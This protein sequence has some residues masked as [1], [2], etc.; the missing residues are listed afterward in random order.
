MKPELCMR[1]TKNVNDGEK[2]NSVRETGEKKGR[3]DV[4]CE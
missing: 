2:E 1:E 3:E 4:K